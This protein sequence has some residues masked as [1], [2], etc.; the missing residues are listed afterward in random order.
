MPT[1]KSSASGTPTSLQ[2]LAGVASETLGEESGSTSSVP[3]PKPPNQTSYN[4]V[5]G[6]MTIVTL[7]DAQNAFPG[8]VGFPSRNSTANSSSSS[9]STSSSHSPDSDRDQEFAIVRIEFNS[10][11]HSW[12]YSWISNR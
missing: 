6:R 10:S 7:T 4:L 2:V 9:S 3:L 11:L 12:D 5:L 8:R 1:A